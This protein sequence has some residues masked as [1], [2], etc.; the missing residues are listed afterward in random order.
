MEYLKDRK[1]R[2]NV[3]DSTISAG[4]LSMHDDVRGPFIVT[5]DRVYELLMLLQALS[6]YSLC[7]E[8]TTPAR[9]A[10]AGLGSL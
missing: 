2:K 7:W 1:E 3:G 4:A 8:V 9:L 6:T 5:R 10:W